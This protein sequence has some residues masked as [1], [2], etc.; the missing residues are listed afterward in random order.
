MPS[1]RRIR[2][3]LVVAVSGM[4]AAL[5]VVLGGL[6][7]TEFLAGVNHAVAV[8]L[9]GFAPVLLVAVGVGCI[10]AYRTIVAMLSE[11]KKPAARATR[12]GGRREREL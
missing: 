8:T 11:S 9:L 6:M 4:G 12:N 3:A 1:S 10:L 5:A 2:V 7:P